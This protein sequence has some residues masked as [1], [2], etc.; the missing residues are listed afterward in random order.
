MTAA[1]IL[2]PRL[3]LRPYA[4]SDAE[5]RRELLDANDAHLRPWIPWMRDEPLSLEATRA[6]LREHAA[7]FLRREMFRYVIALAE[8]GRMIG[9][10]G[11]YPRVGPNALEAGYLVDRR[12]CGRGYARE[13]AAA[14]VRVAFEIERVGRVE[15][16]CDPANTASVRVAERLGFTLA[17]TRPDEAEGASGEL[18]IWVLGE[19][20]YPLSPAS[21]VPVQA[22]AESGTRLL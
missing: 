21:A 16:H 6:L 20:R 4:E 17:R 7:K 12:A 22:W 18:M 3:L 5:E 10:T 9:E 14:M 19:E 1:R 2:T 11:L 15:L 13:A 8:S